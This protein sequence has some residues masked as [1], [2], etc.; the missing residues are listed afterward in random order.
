[1]T[2]RTRSRQWTQW[3]E[4]QARAALA[5]WRESKQSAEAFARKRG[6]APGRLAYWRK[7]L[8]ARATG[9]FVPVVAPARRDA[10]VEIELRGVT[11]RLR[12]DLAPEIIA[13]IVAAL[14]ST[15]RPC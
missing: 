3:T 2:T 1:M 10:H 13:R 15:T 12:E 11:L 4:A 5:E 14:A 6:F 9:A 8:E 7:R